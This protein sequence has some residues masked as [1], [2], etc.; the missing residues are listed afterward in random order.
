MSCIACGYNAS[1]LLLVMLVTLYVQD[2]N[3]KVTSETLCFVL[4][5]HG[6]ETYFLCTEQ[7]LVLGTQC[8]FLQVAMCTGTCKVLTDVARAASS[9]LGVESVSVTEASAD[10]RASATI[11]E[12]HITLLGT[13]IVCKL[14][15]RKKLLLK[16]CCGPKYNSL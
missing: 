5:L 10:H 9:A 4:V 2:N 7:Q 3:H 11:R 6:F 14:N 15:I 8:S 1:T 16:E 12:V 13:T